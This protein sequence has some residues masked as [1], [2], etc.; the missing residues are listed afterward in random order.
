MLSHTEAGSQAISTREETT[1]MMF[2]PLNVQFVKSETYR[3]WPLE[4][5]AVY[6]IIPA[7]ANTRTGL[8][9]HTTKTIAH[10]ANIS[11]RAVRRSLRRIEKAGELTITNVA[12]QKRQYIYNF[13]ALLT[14]RKHQQVRTGESAV[15]T[16][17]SAVR[18][19]ESAVRTGESA[20][21]QK[22]MPQ[23]PANQA[24]T[25]TPDAPNN[26]VLTTESITTTATDRIP[27]S[28]I[29]KM[30][31]KYDKDFV[32]SVV[33][34]FQDFDGEVHNPGGYFVW[35]CKNG[36]LPRS[37]A[38]QKKAEARARREAMDRKQARLLEERA[39]MV[40]GR[41]EADEEL[42]AAAF[43]EIQSILSDDDGED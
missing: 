10:I 8:F 2:A 21:Q 17:E 41:E 43:A 3:T 25:E 23:T 33:V 26:R 40:K 27:P 6:G 24:S 42:A 4:T 32:R 13:A 38:A 36:I 9:F 14:A 19:G 29:G 31:M 22:K 35:C 15:R 20:P 39:E 34:A 5:K 28:L 7:L 1:S 11:P 30:L 37:A 18:T 16:G 12:Y